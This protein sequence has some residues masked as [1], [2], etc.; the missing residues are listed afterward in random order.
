MVLRMTSPWQAPSRR[1]VL[2][3]TGVAAV[4][5]TLPGVA[6]ATTD[7]HPSRART[8]GT[9]TFAFVTD[10]HFDPDN[11]E[12]SEALGRVFAAIEAENPTLVV[13]GGDV[14]D[15]GSAYQYEAYCELVPASLRG[16]MV[17]VPGN[18]D[19]RQDASAY[20]T[21]DRFLANDTYGGTRNSSVVTPDG[22]HWLMPDPTI[23]Q[24]SAV[25]CAPPM[26]AWMRETLSEHRDGPTIVVTHH[27]PI[28]DEYYFLRNPQAFAD[29]V[30]P[31]PVRGVLCGHMHNE[32]LSTTNGITVLSGDA[33]KQVQ[34]GAGYYLLTRDQGADHD[35]LRIDFV[36][37]SLAAAARRH[38]VT[39][40][41]AAKAPDLEPVEVSANA[42]QQGAV[43]NVRA[44]FRAAQPVKSVE[45]LVYNRH[46]WVERDKDGET[47]T[48]LT[49][50]GNE[51]RAALPLGKEPAGEHRA[52]VRVEGTG[53]ARWREIVTF[54]KTGET[55]TPLW[56]HDMGS[57]IHN[58]MTRRDGLVVVATE[59]GQVSAFA[60]RGAN[61][62]LRWTIR[63]GPVYS[64]LAF[65]ADGSAIYA[66]SRDHHLYALDSGTGR[67]LWRADLGVPVMADPLVTSIGGEPRIVVFA[68][69]TLLC[70][71]PADGGEV[72]NRTFDVRSMGR[73]ACDGDTIYLGLGDGTARAVDARDPATDR[74]TRQLTDYEDRHQRLTK[75]PWDCLVLLAGRTAVFGTKE[76]CYG[77][78]VGDGT[79]VWDRKDGSYMFC[80]AGSVG[81]SVLIV[82]ETGHAELIDPATGA[83]AWQASLD[84]ELFGPEVVRR[85][86]D[87]Y[88]T[89]ST[90]SVHHL[91]LRTGTHREL[92]QL[93]KEGVIATPALCDDG[94]VFVLGGID[95]MLQAFA[96]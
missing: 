16:K 47:W 93:S 9:T 41:L 59:K 56:K 83:P 69:E 96:R 2:Q 27:P 5:S 71:D 34:N 39:V 88:L 8:A 15:D 17:H 63:I 38:V 18:H 61:K 28:G 44:R 76:H 55:F 35:T 22:L 10:T 65:S 95:G 29:A 30:R 20:E 64:R 68:G 40:D 14:T 6:H 82:D 42:A 91:G 94:K 84:I 89:S 80:P 12:R 79:D 25:Q 70:L 19:V 21:Y 87:A 60:P 23:T 33:L 46:L 13:N 72:W 37:V 3:A 74:W 66:P 78:D 62:R 58:A 57:T 43:V 54:H 86:D 31:F 24:Q 50:D 48:P 85:G 36:P 26:L 77:L 32:R 7:D 92:R 1:Q 49:A 4:A 11:T 90:G 52:I 51:Y 45:A 67:E 75:G 53:G 81:E 73:V